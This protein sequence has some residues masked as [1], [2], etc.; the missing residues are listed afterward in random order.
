MV[1]QCARWVLETD[2]RLDG[3]GSRLL[4]DQVTIAAATGL[5]PHAVGRWRTRMERVLVSAQTRA[6]EHFERGFVP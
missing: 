5:S 3:E 6:C 1:L 2:G 4:R